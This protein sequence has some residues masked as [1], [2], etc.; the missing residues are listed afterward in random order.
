MVAVLTKDL[1]EEKARSEAM[2]KLAAE[3]QEK[4]FSSA[5]EKC[6]RLALEV[7]RNC[8]KG[9]SNDELEARA[10]QA[11][12]EAG[13]KAAAAESD[14]SRAVR[15]LEPLPKGI[16]SVR[17]GGCRRQA[18]TA[19]LAN[20]SLKFPE[21][22]LL[23]GEELKVDLLKEVGSQRVVYQHGQD[24]YQVSF[25]E[26]SQLTLSVSPDGASARCDAGMDLPQIKRRDAALNAKEYLEQHAVLQYLQGL[27][28]ALVQDKP[29]DPYGYMWQQLN[30][31]R[32][33]PPPPPDPRTPRTPD[34]EPWTL[35]SADLKDEI[36]EA[37]ERSSERF[38]RWLEAMAEVIES[39]TRSLGGQGDKE[40]EQKESERGTERLAEA[41]RQLRAALSA[42]AE[43]GTLRG[44][45]AETAADLR[46]APPQGERPAVPRPKPRVKDMEPCPQESPAATGQE[47]PTDGSN[48]EMREACCLLSSRILLRVARRDAHSRPVEAVESPP[49]GKSPAVPRPKP[50][51][52]D[53]EPCPQ[54]S[55]AAT[56]QEMP[57]DGSN[58]EMREA[59]CLLSSRILLRVAR[60]EAHSRPVEAVESPPQGK[61]PAVPRPKPRVKDMEP[62][63]QECSAET[64]QESTTD[65][66]NQEMWEACCLL[67]S[68]ILLRVARREAHSKLVEDVHSKPSPSDME[69]VDSKPSPSGMEAVDSKPSP[70][71]MDA[72]DSKPNPSDTDVV[73]S[74]QSPSDME[75]VDS[76]PSP[77]DMEAVDSKPSPSGMEAVDSKP[78]P[79]DAQAVDSKQSP[80]D[81]EAVDS[82]PSPSDMQ[83]VDSKPSPSDMEAV[84][85]KPSPSDAQAV[86]SKQ[87]PSDM[88]AVDSKPS[89]SDMQAV[90]SKP[91]PSDM[92]AVDSKPS[93]SGMEAVDSKP[94][95]SGMEAV[96][97]KPSPSDMDAVDSKPSPAE[98]DVVDSKPSPSDMEAVDS[99][100]SPSDAQAVDSKPTPS[101][102]EAVDSKPSPSDMQAVDSKPSPPD[103]DAVDSKPSSSDMQAVN[104][105]SRPSDMETMPDRVKQL[106]AASEFFPDECTGPKEADGAKRPVE[107]S[108]PKVCL[109][110]LQ[111]SFGALRQRQSQLRH[112]VSLLSTHLAEVRSS[113]DYASKLVNQ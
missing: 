90:D 21:L 32:T 35:P 41:R 4:A 51:V 44:L 71:D 72:V 31:A 88:E 78:S 109:L 100:P 80:S 13:E 24:R 70:S 9:G 107:P 102:M 8:P 20:R 17:L 42:A 83:A 36:C 112:K 19:A 59:C 25:G 26:A 16:L 48:Q 75:A 27:L 93:P 15:V 55:P 54:E 104:S 14:A 68:R 37:L 1:E 45:L 81:M 97:S 94:S 84:D 67:S 6:A 65:S 105:K 63:P 86:D 28:E 69:A 5:K 95:P 73:D 3:Y 87:S 60:R 82:K 62:C 29:E 103:M 76:K 108:K 53:M 64:G 11:E 91:S 50:R 79:S 111:R 61:S 49:Q 46:P 30:F 98:T 38:P 43:D 52:K 40:K 12:A 7:E 34:A 113:T 57:T 74:K 58:Q 92:E 110:E 18:S 77:S 85:S 89:P 106:P 39:Q 2:E 47:M 10:L 23:A 33:P 99:K 56:G 96:D 101:D 22:P 66:S